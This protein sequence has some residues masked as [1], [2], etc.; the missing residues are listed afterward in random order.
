MTTQNTKGEKMN[1]VPLPHKPSVTTNGGN[2]TG[3]SSP[4]PKEAYGNNWKGE[5]AGK[6][7]KHTFLTKHY[8]QPKVCDNPF[9]EGKSKFYDWCLKSGRKYSHNK[10]DYYRMCRSCHRKYD[11]NE[12]KKAQAMKNLWWNSK[13]KQMH[14]V[15]EGHGSSKFKSYQIIEI[16][17]KY[18]NG[19]SQ[20]KL[21]RMYDTSPANIG[22][23]VRRETWKHL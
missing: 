15:G 5:K 23:I 21:G 10:E 16:R 8:G 17:E 3:G 18:A 14:L 22:S 4:Q 7:A 9:C 11:L 6:S 20:A 13:T 1:A 12:K 19:I 2:T